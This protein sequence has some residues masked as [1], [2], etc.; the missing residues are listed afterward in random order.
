ME[1]IVQLFSEGDAIRTVCVGILLPPVIQTAALTHST[2]FV[3]SK[4]R[5]LLPLQEE[6]LACSVSNLPRNIWLQSI[7]IAV[8]HPGCEQA[9]NFR[10][11][12][13]LPDAKL[14]ADRSPVLKD[15]FFSYTTKQLTGYRT[16]ACHIRHTGSLWLSGNNQLET[17]DVLKA[18]TAASQQMGLC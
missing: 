4:G 12:T 1:G 2:L 8:A 3:L 14:D 7:Q 13:M 11:L 6:M 18:Q 9:W 16:L 5:H 17:Q 15:G 10:P